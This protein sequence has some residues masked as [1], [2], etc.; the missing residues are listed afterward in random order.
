M[1]FKDIV[2][3]ILYEKLGPIDG[4]TDVWCKLMRLRSQC[5]RYESDSRIG[6]KLQVS[7][8]FGATSDISGGGVGRLRCSTYALYSAERVTLLLIKSGFLPK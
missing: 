6:P 1:R 5:E 4:F 3:P 7:M 2:L 8:G